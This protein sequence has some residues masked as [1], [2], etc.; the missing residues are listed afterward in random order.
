MDT[1]C[2]LKK[3][4]ELQM[5][6]QTIYTNYKFF[7][8]TTKTGQKMTL[9]FASVDDSMKVSEGGGVDTEMIELFYLPIDSTKQFLLDEQKPKPS[10]LSYALSWYLLNKQ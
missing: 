10:S 3:L 1:K 4:K 5:Y 9:F 2:Q 7:I 6:A 8:S